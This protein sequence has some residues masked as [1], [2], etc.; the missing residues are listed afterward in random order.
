MMT[1]LP[2]NDYRER[3][4]RTPGADFTTR[5]FEAIAV[6]RYVVAPSLLGDA[7]LA[8][9]AR[10]ISA[11]RLAGDGSNFEHWYAERFGRTIVPAREEDGTAAAAREKLRGAD[12]EVPVDLG[13]CSPF[14]Q[15]VLR[16]AA[17][18]G[19]GHARPYHWV[20]REMGAPDATRAV[21]NAL[22]A[23][24]VPLVIPCHR[25]IRSD[26]SVGGYVFGGEAKR[27]LLEAEG[28]DFAA[29]GNLVGGGYKFVGCDEGY[30]CLP[31]CGDVARRLHE[32]GYR[33]LRDL[34]DAHSHG[35]SPCES[36][37]PAAA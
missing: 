9:N 6:D 7:F 21:G 12:V 36:C 15:R 27:R 14:E 22:G 35:L 8:W 13:S 32:P 25:V 28:L 20:A 23:N 31:T 34:A 30:F 29:I 16:A 24:P 19:A 3:T 5:V 17:R 2:L 37:R 10:G 4:R 11:V 26:F 18:I 1:D 33:P